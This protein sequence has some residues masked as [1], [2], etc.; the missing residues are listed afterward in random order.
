MEVRKIDG[1][2]VRALVCLDVADYDPNFDPTSITVSSDVGEYVV[3]MLYTSFHSVGELVRQ[4]NFSERVPSVAQSELEDILKRPK[5]IP[6]EWRQF[7]LVAAKRVA[8]GPF[9]S[10]FVPCAYF[11]G[12]EWHMGFIWLDGGGA[13]RLVTCA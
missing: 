4:S 1:R 6:E 2:S 13:D 5:R 3:G 12:D 8:Q 11:S 7:I 9:A 10:R